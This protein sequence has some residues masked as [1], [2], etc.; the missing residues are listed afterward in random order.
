MRYAYFT[1]EVR[2]S[3]ALAAGSLMERA[4]FGVATIAIRLLQDS[5]GQVVGSKILILVGTG[6]NGGDALFAGAN[7]AGRGAQV[8]ALLMGNGAHAKGLA[9]LR[10]TQSEIVVL[11]DLVDLT[12]F[13]LVIDGILGI[14]AK[15]GLREDAARIVESLSEES[16]ILA[17]D[18]PSGVDA[19]SGETPGAHVTADVTAVCGALKIANVVAPAAAAAGTSELIEIGLEFPANIA[20]VEIWQGVDVRDSLPQLSSDL[21]KYRRGVVGVIAGSKEFPGAG[22]LVCAGAL[23]AGVGMVRYLGE[24]SETVIGEHPEVV[25]ATGRVQAWVLGSG[26]VDISLTGDVAL[27]I[28]SAQPIVIDAGALHLLPPGRKD[29][30]I[31]PHAG[32]LANLLGVERDEIERRSLHF[33]TLAAETFGVNVLLKG[34]T[35]LVVSPQR[36]M[37]ANPTGTPRLATAGSGDVLAGVIGALAASG[38]PL[39]DAAVIGAWV[40]GL[41]GRLM[42]GSG[43][44]DI[45]AEIPR[46]IESLQW[47]AVRL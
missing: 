42:R 7:L 31:T 16:I 47:Q 38:V 45:A 37:V 21:D 25:R 23:A 30:L 33:A 26:L 13:N 17:V 32:E 12:Q 11:G 22:A 35:T 20:R 46:A 4:A 34:S 39:F 18:L 8:T 27:A 19:D 1:E 43:A 40:H 36:R 10:R 5:V 6:D 2:A 28:A 3:E 9:A 41:A 29:C 44:S 15:G 14:G 24:A